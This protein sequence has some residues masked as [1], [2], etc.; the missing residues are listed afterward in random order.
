MKTKIL[1]SILNLAAASVLAADS[2][3]KDELTSAAKSLAGKDNYAWKSTM[4]FGN[5]SGD[6]EGKT[7]KEGLVSLS[8]NFGNN[9][10]DA[11]LKGGKGAIKTD[12]G[13]QSFSELE[14]GSNGEGRG[15][16]LLLRRLQTYK[17]PA[18]EAIKLLSQTK[19]I[20]KEGE[21]YSAS[22]TE[23]GAKELLT[24]GRRRGG[25]NVEV[26]GAKASVK[27]WIKDGL[28]SKYQL[29]QQGTV[30]AGG[31]EREVDGTTTVE[32]KNVGSTKVEVP[33]EARKKLS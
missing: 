32:I 6:T 31:N 11:V 29:K 30:T 15:R 18:E 26:S 22:L 8:L 19:E 20:K 13:W 28:I 14:S 9:S 24:F 2:D 10:R 16:G 7:D 3:P 23:E 25:E 17:A 1:F 27:F 5:F 21:V 4:E 12:Q 33:E